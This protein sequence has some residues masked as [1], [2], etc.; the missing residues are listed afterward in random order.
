MRESML[1]KME[2]AAAYL[3]ELEADRLATIA[4]SEEKAEEAKLIKARQEG[5]GLLSQV[6]V[7]FRPGLAH[8]RG[9]RVTVDGREEATLPARIPES[10]PRRGELRSLS[11]REAL[12]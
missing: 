9:V 5:L 8:N 2:K 7:D 1:S 3:Q 10:V 6:A 12:A 11:L 4:V